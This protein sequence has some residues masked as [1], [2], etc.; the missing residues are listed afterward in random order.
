MVKSTQSFAMGDLIREADNSETD[1]IIFQLA[2]DNPEWAKQA[3]RVAYAEMYLDAAREQHAQE[4][5]ILQEEL[6]R[7][8]QKQYDDVV[9]DAAREQHAQEQAILQQEQEQKQYDDVVKDVPIF[10]RQI[11]A[12]NRLSSYNS[13]GKNETLQ[14]RRKPRNN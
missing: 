12:L 9:K 6:E 1:H 8:Q 14:L 13:A 11:N 2:K 10:L 7:L 5:A 3:L 4:R